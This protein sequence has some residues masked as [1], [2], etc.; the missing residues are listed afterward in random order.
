MARRTSPIPRTRLTR[1]LHGSRRTPKAPIES[2]NS[3]RGLTAIIPAAGASRR[4][5]QASPL[6]YLQVKRAAFHAAGDR[7]ELA[8]DVARQL[9]GREHHDRARDVVRACDLA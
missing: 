3:F 7:D 1:L 6:S 8:G 9:V 2:R 4:R 5:R